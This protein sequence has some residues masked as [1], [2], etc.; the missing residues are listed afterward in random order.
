[1]MGEL[2]GNVVHLRQLD[3]FLNGLIISYGQAPR[4]G[5]Q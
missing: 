4:V 2:Q 5:G 1:M 3:H